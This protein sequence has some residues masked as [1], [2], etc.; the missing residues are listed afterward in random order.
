MSPTANERQRDWFMDD[1]DLPPMGEETEA[2][3]AIMSPSFKT[4]ENMPDELCEKY[5]KVASLLVKHLKDCHRLAQNTFARIDDIL[6][7]EGN[8]G[9]SGPDNSGEKES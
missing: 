5:Y 3:K 2:F 6:M 1:C 9:N 8:G 7:D 4:R